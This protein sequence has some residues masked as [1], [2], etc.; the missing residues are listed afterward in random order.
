M[1]CRVEITGQFNVDKLMSAW[2]NK[3]STVERELA[4]TQ[5][6]NWS[7]FCDSADDA[8]QPMLGTKKKFRVINT[9]FLVVLFAV[10]VG[11]MALI[12]TTSM[13]TNIWR[14]AVPYIALLIPFLF[15]WFWIKSKVKTTMSDLEKVCQQFSG[16]SNNA[17]SGEFRYELHS[18]HWLGGCTKPHVKRYFI[19]LHAPSGTEGG[20]NADIEQP[21]VSTPV[22]A[23][24]PAPTAA[25]PTNDEL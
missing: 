14:I 12:V 6:P 15:F 1:T 17:T 9:I 3:E 16:S 10:F 20:D 24:Y 22:A 23:Y 4:T 7:S 8:L 19:T 13:L 25:P 21:V 5:P 2:N 18:E 11:T